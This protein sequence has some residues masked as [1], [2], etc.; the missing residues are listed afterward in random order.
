[1]NDKDLENM[2]DPIASQMVKISSRLQ[3]RVVEEF[4]PIV[5]AKED[6]RG[7]LLYEG[8]IHKVDV[9]SYPQVSSMAAV[10]GARIQEKLYAGDFLVALATLANALRTP[11]KYEAENLLWADI[12]QHVDGTDRVS[13]TAMGS[14]EVHL[15]S[16][17][18]HEVRIMD[19]SF[20]TPLIML[21]EGLFIKSHKIQAA[22]AQILDERRSAESLSYLIDR[23][24][25]G[26]VSIAKS[27][28]A[29]YFAKDFDEKFG[30]RFPI[31]DRFLATQILQPGEIFEPRVLRELE[32][33]TVDVPNSSNKDVLKQASLLKVEYERLGKMAKQG[34]IYTTYYRPVII[35]NPEAVSGKNVI[36]IEFVVNEEDAKNVVEIAKRYAGVLN[37]DM[38]GPY[39]LEPYCQHLVDRQAKSISETAKM[40]KNQMIAKLPSDQAAAY[41]ELLMRGYRT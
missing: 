30:L 36:R 15:L 8:L 17:A 21:R 2:Q 7:K 27:D 34:L 33:Q 1:M 11:E 41:R 25:D 39:M 6:L 19:G 16:R 23:A 40:F 29:T 14:G 32:K 12:M 22:S 5:G 13:Q 9:S 38:M 4:S 35:G 31:S 28:S 24:H 20:V 10:D 18:K 26:L 37:S 3:E